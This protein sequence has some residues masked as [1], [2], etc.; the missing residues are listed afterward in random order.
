MK[1]SNK[2]LIILAVALFVIPVVGMVYYAKV[3]R[4]DGK[5]Y[6]AAIKNEGENADVAD[7]FLISRKVEQFDK[8]VI[9]GSNNLYTSVSIVKS[10]VPLVKFTKNTESVFTTSVD[11]QTRTLTIKVD[12]L[13]RYRYSSIFV[14]VPDLESITLNNLQISK[15]D[16]DF[17]HVNIIASNI[18]NSLNFGQ[19]SGLKSLTLTVKDSRFSIGKSHRDDSFLTGLEN[20]E[21]NVI[22]GGVSLAPMN[23]KSISVNLQNSDFNFINEDRRDQTSASSIQDL[24]INSQGIAD[25]SLPEKTVEIGKLS[26]SLSDSTT[27]DLPHYKVKN[28][29]NK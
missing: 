5:M 17:D 2:L 23:Y 21:L 24:A 26:G 15:F 3:N 28:L 1:T 6:D 12:S 25:I 7:R 4:V 14:F 13:K 8:V 11:Q 27:T 16:T 10:N 9:E 18:N 19:N 22:N 29:F 20:F